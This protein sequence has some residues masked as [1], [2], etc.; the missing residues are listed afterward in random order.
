MDKPRLCSDCGARTE[1]QLVDQEYE[2]HGIRVQLTGLP[3][4]VCPACGS[5][6]FDPN[7]TEDIM[8]AANAMFKIA[9]NRHKGVLSASAVG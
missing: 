8:A 9:A 4:M 5:I 2:R 7:T 1:W 3:A 6:S